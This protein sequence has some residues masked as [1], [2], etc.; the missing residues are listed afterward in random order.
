MSI[1][2]SLLFV[3]LI[4]ILNVLSLF[5]KK[6]SLCI[7]IFSILFNTVFFLSIMIILYNGILPVKNIYE[8]NW[9][10]DIYIILFCAVLFVGN[11]VLCIISYK[12][13]FFKCMII[14]FCC[15]LIGFTIYYFIKYP[16][17]M[18]YEWIEIQ[19]DKSSVIPA[20]L[21]HFIVNYVVSLFLFVF[22]YC[23]KIIGK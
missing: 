23:K 18:E 21:S 9:L 3:G 19:L 5:L 4:L 14:C 13:M 7:Q 8:N 17:Y 20:P 6:K 10:S 11:A 12:I 15:I 1:L 2:I 22:L 16:P